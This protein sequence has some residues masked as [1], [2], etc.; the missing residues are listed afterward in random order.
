M[1]EMRKLMEAVGEFVGEE[2]TSD[3]STVRVLGK[4]TFSMYAEYS[5]NDSDSSQAARILNVEVREY[6]NN[7]FVDDGVHVYI[8]EDGYDGF[9][10][11]FTLEDFKKLVNTVGKLFNQG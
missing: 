5:G 11:E 3:T 1:N 7:K 6:K 2:R 10:L 4:T 9:N 8:S